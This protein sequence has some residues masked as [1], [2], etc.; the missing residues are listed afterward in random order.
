L[1]DSVYISSIVDSDLTRLL[2]FNKFVILIRGERLIVHEIT[3]I[4]I[5][6]LLFVLL[7]IVFIF[8]V[9][10]IGQ[11]FPIICS[12]GPGHLLENLRLL[13]HLVFK[14]VQ[15]ELFLSDFWILFRLIYSLIGF[16]RFLR[17]NLN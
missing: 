17:G 14:I 8:P 1:R 10:S 4:I 11:E 2:Y 7:I 6:L 12:C 15:N 5:F 3:E 9:I 16:N 13:W